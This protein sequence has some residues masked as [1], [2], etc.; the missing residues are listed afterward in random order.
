MYDNRNEF[1]FE[2]TKGYVFGLVPDTAVISASHQDNRPQPARKS[3]RLNQY[4]RLLE[5]VIQHKDAELLD[6]RNL[7]E[8]RIREESEKRVANEHVMI[9]Q[10]RRAAMGEMLGAIAHQ[11]RQP[12]NALSMIVQ[13]MKDAWEYGEFSGELMDHSVSSAMEQIRFMSKTID[14]FRN[15]FRP[16]SSTEHFCPKQCVDE[17]VAM[18]SGWF[19]N[20]V[21]IPIEIIDTLGDEV[22]VQGCHNEFKQ[23]ILNLLCNARDAILKQPQKSSGPR[24]GLITIR[25]FREGASVFI[26][27]KDNG[28]GI[29]ESVMERIFEPYFT[30]KEVANG[31][32][33]GLY[34]S[35]V[36]VETKMY[37]ALWAENVSDGAQFVMSL[38]A[39]PQLSGGADERSDTGYLAAVC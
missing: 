16:R 28:G 4:V 33:I 36:I 22:K 18:V 39:I 6:M 12:L 24:S 5:G 19:S 31:S 26:G 30:T 14:V 2:P 27:V 35:K 13:N 1:T 37:G 9:H 38:P 11:W 25:L 21:T 17:V 34:M 23:V 3:I 29:D 20:F 32:G 15:F 10:A 7:L 8:Q